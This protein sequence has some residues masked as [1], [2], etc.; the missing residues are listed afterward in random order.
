MAIFHNSGGDRVTWWWM[1]QY[2]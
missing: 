1:D 2:Q